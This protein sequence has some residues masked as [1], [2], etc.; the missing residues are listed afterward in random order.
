MNKIKLRHAGLV[1]TNLNK[2][3]YF[4]QNLL[5]L[6]IQKRNYESGHFIDKILKLKNIEVETI[7]M[8]ANDGS[9]IELLYFKSHPKKN[10]PKRKIYTIGP[11]HLAFTVENLEA[12]YKRLEK[13]G[14]KFNSLPSISPDGLVKVAFCKDPDGTYIELV[15]EL[16]NKK[17]N[18]KVRFYKL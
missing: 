14:V 16:K 2:S 15:E 8:S 17:P 7:K 11:S 5:G 4:Y 6:K 9:L 3:L 12:V 10:D 1:I 18:L 13:A